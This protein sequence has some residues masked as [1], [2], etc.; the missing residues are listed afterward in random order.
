MRLHSDVWLVSFSILLLATS[1]AAGRRHRHGRHHSRDR[2]Q[3][4]HGKHST[5]RHP[6]PV[7]LSKTWKPEGYPDPIFEPR[8]CRSAHTRFCDPDAVLLKDESRLVEE[9]L[10][11]NRMFHLS[12]SS[13]YSSSTDDVVADDDAMTLV[14]VQIAVALVEKVRRS[15]V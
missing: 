9:Y 2:K 3:Q 12:C 1:V 11:I 10:Q 8:K 15:V 7:R 6:P 5:S 13:H 14:E 4:Q